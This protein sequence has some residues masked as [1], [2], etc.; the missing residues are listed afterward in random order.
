[1]DDEKYTKINKNQSMK[2]I[3]FDI[4]EISERPMH[5]Q[6]L[7]RIM[8]HIVG[9]RSQ[10]KCPCATLNSEIGRDNK[11]LKNRGIV[12]LKDWKHPANEAPK[13]IDKSQRSNFGNE[14]LKDFKKTLNVKIPRTILKNEMKESYGT[15]IIEHDNFPKTYRVPIDRTR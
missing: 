5:Y 3:A 4:L 8:I 1:M 11:F 9:Y 12:E 15:G 10:G 14:I 6:E 7:T 2:N 13:T